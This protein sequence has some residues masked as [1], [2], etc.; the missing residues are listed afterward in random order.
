[1]NKLI[2]VLLLFALT[3]TA[4]LAQGKK[5][6][7]RIDHVI[8]EARTYIGTPYVWGGNTKKGVDCSGLIHNCYKK[9][10]V[11][12]PRTA[13]E[14]SKIGSSKSWGSIR[15]GD[16]VYF[17]FKQKRDK[18]YHSGMITSVDGDEI[19]FIHAS[20]SR[21]VV[22]SNLN[23]DYYKKNVKKFRRVIK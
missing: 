20:S 5:K 22:E 6:Q 10:N 1:M 11:N 23:S 17:K 8:A 16:I 15:P 2:L 21:G 19:K 18:W 9:I 13:E 12:L 14:Q 4:S 3:V 7:K